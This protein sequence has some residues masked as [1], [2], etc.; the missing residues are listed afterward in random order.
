MHLLQYYFQVPTTSGT[1]SEV[2]GT[3]VFDYL[4][5]KTKTGISSRSMI[6]LLAIVDP[7]HALSMPKNIVTFTG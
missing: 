1:G 2:T 3:S 5:L 7:I 4:P 6:P